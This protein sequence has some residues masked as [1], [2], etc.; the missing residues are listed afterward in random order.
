VHHLAAADRAAALAQRL[1][2]RVPGLR[3]LHVQEVGAV[4]G[5]HVG[6]GMLAVVIAPQLPPPG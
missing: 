2:N 6:P 3:D 4:I 5:A 1:R